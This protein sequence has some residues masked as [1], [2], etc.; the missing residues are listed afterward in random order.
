VSILILSLA[1]TD[2]LAALVT[3]T[4]GNS[5]PGFNDGDTPTILQILA[6]QSGQ[7]APFDACNGND[8][9]GPDFSASWSFSYGA[10][11]ETITQASVTVGIA[12][13]ES[14]SPGNQLASFTFDGN[15]LTSS[16]NTA[17][18]SAGGGQ[19]EFNIYT[20]SLPGSTFS[21]LVDGIAPF[22][23]SLQ[24]PVQKIPLLGGPPVTN[25]FNGACIIFSTLDITTQPSTPGGQPVGGEFVGIDTVSVLLAGTQ[26]T[27]AWMIPVI[28]AGIGFA[29]VI[30]RKF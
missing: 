22:S 7:P 21:D 17:F 28:V 24:G 30:A 27:A 1:I 3:I 13:H 18:E 5:S 14:A 4:L 2:S 20:I 29:I 15:A 12:Q 9:L 19:D 23:L 11:S 8:V 10:L 25:N 6:A 16:L 26:T